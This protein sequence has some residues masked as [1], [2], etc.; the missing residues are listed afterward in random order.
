MIIIIIIACS[1]LHELI[2][3]VCACVKQ[4]DISS[5]DV[6]AKTDSLKLQVSY[7]S[8]TFQN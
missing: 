8:Q 1:L 6:V 7:I 2:H 5:G 3:V 4:S